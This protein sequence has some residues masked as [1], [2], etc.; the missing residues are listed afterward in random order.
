MSINPD[1]RTVETRVTHIPGTQTPITPDEPDAFDAGAGVE[2]LMV[3]A[4]RRV[5][6]VR[7]VGWWFQEAG[8]KG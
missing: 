1:Y 6:R 7:R 8:C 5:R 4:W 2:G 3:D